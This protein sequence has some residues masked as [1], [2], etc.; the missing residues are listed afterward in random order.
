[1]KFP[2]LLYVKREKDGD[3]E[4]VSYLVADEHLINLAALGEITEI[5]I[6]KLSEIID[7]KGIVERCAKKRK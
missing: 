2:K 5:A 4:D 1:M 6:Y 3:V 7:V